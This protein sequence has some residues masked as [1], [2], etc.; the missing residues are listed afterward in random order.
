[1]PLVLVPLTKWWEAGKVKHSVYFA[2][3]NSAI[4]L[5]LVVIYKNNPASSTKFPTYFGL[6][7][8][9]LK[10]DT[11]SIPRKIT[12]NEAICIAFTRPH[13]MST[14][15]PEG[16]LQ[17]QDVQ[18]ARASPT[19]QFGPDSREPLPSQLSRTQLPSTSSAQTVKD[20]DN[21]LVKLHS[22]SNF[23]SFV[24][25]IPPPV[26]DPLLT[27]FRFRGRCGG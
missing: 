11:I 15:F 23:L 16:H 17:E 22:K 7:S 24:D 18:A 26:W 6:P 21:Q 3:A 19:P 27:L 14:P 12:I 4:T 10:I 8:Y 20:S 25:S 13:P 9:Q 1:M 2:I 5:I